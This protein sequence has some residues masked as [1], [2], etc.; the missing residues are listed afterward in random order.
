MLG[1]QKKMSKERPVI[2][3]ETEFV[4]GKKYKETILGNEGVATA[5][6]V[7][8]TGCDQLK[9]TW[10]DS[11]GRPVDRWVDVSEIESPSGVVEEEDKKGR[12]G[13]PPLCEFGDK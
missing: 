13:G 5:G 3:N 10:N 11:T 8:L 2:L 1:E 4:L 6:A 9:I 12:P 7:Y